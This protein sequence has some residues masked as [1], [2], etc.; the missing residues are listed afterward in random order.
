MPAHNGS[1]L[2]FIDFCSTENRCWFNLKDGEKDA[3]DLGVNSGWF[4]LSSSETNKTKLGLDSFPSTM[5]S[6]SATSLCDDR[7][8]MIPQS[9]TAI[10]RNGSSPD[11]TINSGVSEELS[12]GSKMVIGVA[13]GLCLLGLVCLGASLWLY[14]KTGS[15][16]A[17]PVAGN[18][19]RYTRRLR[20]RKPR[21]QLVAELDGRQAPQELPAW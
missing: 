3:Q 1:Y 20:D 6:K 5:A 21:Q 18:H 13:A 19:G 2:V 15:R 14:K 16:G 7:N 9:P 4:S 11:N 17:S 12:L 10:D 8:T